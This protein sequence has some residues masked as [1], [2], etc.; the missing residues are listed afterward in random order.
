MN[1]I[2]NYKRD[3]KKFE[4]HLNKL[5]DYPVSRNGENAW[6]TN[7]GESINTVKKIMA[8]NTPLVTKMNYEA[9]GGIADQ[10]IYS[11]D[12]AR[13]AKGV[14]YIS[15]KSSDEKISDTLKYGGMKKFTGAYFILI[16]YLKKG[17]KVRSLE[18]MPLY[19]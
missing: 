4:Y 16:E 3:P 6:V 18:A 11:A 8:K 19:L 1:Y 5:F 2:K 12:E 17:K 15:V 10:T 14:G 9:H 7:G 13:K